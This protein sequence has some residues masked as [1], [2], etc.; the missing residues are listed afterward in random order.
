M[1]NSK[2]PEHPSLEYLKKL[3]KERLQ[4]LRRADPRA[5]LAAALLA[6]AR[7]HG[8]PRWRAPQAGDQRRPAAEAPPLLPTLAPRGGRAPARPAPP[9]APRAARAITS[10]R[11]SR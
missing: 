10:S 4:E 3:A 1:S 7:D 5:K 6:V 9:R 11:P 2:L 8:F